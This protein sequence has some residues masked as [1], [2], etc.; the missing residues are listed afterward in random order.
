MEWGRLPEGP[1]REQAKRASGKIALPAFQKGVNLFAAFQK[2]A[3]SGPIETA[4]AYLE[5]ELAVLD[6]PHRFMA[7]QVLALRLLDAYLA[8]GALNQTPPEALARRTLDA[9]TQAVVA[10]ATEQLTAHNN[11]NAH[12]VAATLQTLRGYWPEATIRMHAQKTLAAA[13]AYLARPP[14]DTCPPTP[15]KTTS[16]NSLENQIRAGVEALK[17]LAQ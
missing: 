2:E 9:E 3:A 8:D 6:E 16:T 5:R 10:F 12:L 1:E 17:P 15:A 7:G 11:P 14:C 4:L 13:E